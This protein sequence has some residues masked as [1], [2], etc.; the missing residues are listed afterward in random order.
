MPIKTIG[1]AVALAALCLAGPTLLCAAQTPWALVTPDEEARD[2]AAP[3]VPGPPDL[4]SPPTINL[5][6]PD[7][8][9]PLQNPV[10][11]EVRFHPGPGK[12]IDMQSFRATYGWLSIDITRRL[13]EHAV[14]TSNSLLAENVNLP[15]GRHRI[16]L[17]ISD[18]SGKRASRTF[19]FSVTR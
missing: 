15:I 16:T 18:T 7:L 4:P 1:I 17:S 19:R 9:R 3:Q 12:T 11:I 10:T 2:R 8:S 5:V 14:A 6:R 13:L